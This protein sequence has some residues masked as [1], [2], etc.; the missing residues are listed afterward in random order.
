MYMYVY[1][2]VYICVH[3]GC[4]CEKKY[5]I[6]FA[7]HKNSRIFR[8]K[9]SFVDKFALKKSHFN[10]A[11][12]CMNVCLYIPMCICPSIRSYLRTNIIRYMSIVYLYLQDSTID[13]VL[14]FPKTKNLPATLTIGL[15]L[16]TY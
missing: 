6:D 12:I 4:T 15:F 14:T 13:S 5:F 8:K 2:Y 9:S 3:M 1:V 16:E 10:I 7:K 11:H